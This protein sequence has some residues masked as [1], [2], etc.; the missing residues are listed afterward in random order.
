MKNHPKIKTAVIGAGIFF[1]FVMAVFTGINLYVINYSAPYIYQSIEDLPESQTVI[2]PGAMVYKNTV[3]HVVRDRTEAALNCINAGKAGRILVSGDHGRKGYDEVNGIKN[4]MTKNY[5]VDTNIIFLDHAGFST[6]ETMYRARDIF[7]VESAIISTQKF[8]T[9]R[10]VYIARKLGINA[11]AIEAPEI[12][13]YRR[14]VKAS[15][16]VRE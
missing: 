2:I 11:V 4:F 14:Q 3:S 13:A 6:Y 15:W 10:S 5:K 16:A 8:H 1:L 9:A 12:L 7:C